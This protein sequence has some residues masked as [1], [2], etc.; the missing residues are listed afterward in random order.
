MNYTGFRIVTGKQKISRSKKNEISLYEKEYPSAVSKKT[1]INKAIPA[2]T[3]DSEREYAE[4]I[5][6]AN[7]KIVTH[8]SDKPEIN[9]GVLKVICV[10][11]LIVA[12][13]MWIYLLDVEPPEYMKKSLESLMEIASGTKEE[14]VSTQSEIP[15]KEDGES[16]DPQSEK[17]P[18]NE[19]N[20]E[21]IE[22]ISEWNGI[23]TEENSHI[24]ASIVKEAENNTLN[25]SEKITNIATTENNKVPENAVQVIARNM[26]V[27]SD[28]IYLSNKTDLVLDGA[29]LLENEYPIEK[30]KAGCG[31]PLVLIVH[32]HGTEAYLNS[33]GSVTRSTDTERNIVRVGEELANALRLFGI[34]VIHS[35][36]MHDEVS[37][38]NA[39]A[40]SKAEV[41]QY[42]SEYPSIKYVIDVHRDAISGSSEKPIKTYTE[43]NGEPTAQLMLVMGTN[44][45]GGNHPNFMN[46]LTVAAHLQNEANEKYPTL[47]RAMNIRPIIFNQNLADGC[48]ILEVGSDAN[49]LEEALNAARMFARCF[50]DVVVE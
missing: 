3:R 7:E 1:Y 45:A 48:M 38:V 29:Q 11:L 39:Y 22:P 25:T 17:K 12:L 16:I 26:S 35:K 36:T 47:M 6:S 9:Y 8:S 43:I 49:T 18:V 42:L 30:Y 27:G 28:K 34:E 50:G 20:Y 40:N 15:L 44:A 24:A 2:S 31:E 41:M 37:Y 13:P 23:S 19:E 46:N 4:K 5:C 21:S 10:L 14:N 33:G 32:T